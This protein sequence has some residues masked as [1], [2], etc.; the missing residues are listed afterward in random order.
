MAGDFDGNSGDVQTG[1]LTVNVQGAE[2]DSMNQMYA[3]A[4]LAGNA[5]QASASGSNCQLHEYQTG[6]SPNKFKRAEAPGGSGP[7]EQECITH[8]MTV[9]QA[10][11]NAYIAVNSPYVF[12]SEVAFMNVEIVFDYDGGGLFSCEAALD[13]IIELANWVVPETVPEDPELLGAV[14]TICELATGEADP[15]S[16]AHSILA[17]GS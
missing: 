1:S 9:C 17:G 3:M 10:S 4:A 15:W 6:C 5:I 12:P 8:N 7:P 2:Y 14:Q 13:A 11:N 16:V